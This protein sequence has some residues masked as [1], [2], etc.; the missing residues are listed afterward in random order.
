M[1]EKTDQLIEQPETAPMSLTSSTKDSI[2]KI[3]RT[4][5]TNTKAPGIT[6]TA[7]KGNNGELYIT[8]IRQIYTLIDH[9]ALSTGSLGNKNLTRTETPRYGVKED[10]GYQSSNV[11]EFCKLGSIEAHATVSIG[12]IAPTLAS[13]YTSVP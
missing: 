12:S 5:G 7:V 9:P 8:D 6:R 4:D 10:I 13:A 11:T 1:Y 2:Y 3:A